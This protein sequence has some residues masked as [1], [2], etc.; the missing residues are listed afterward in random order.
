M[1][2][3]IIALAIASLLPLSGI[4]QPMM[5]HSS[6]HNPCI[7]DGTKCNPM[8]TQGMH[9]GSWHNKNYRGYENHRQAMFRS[10]NLS[11]EQQAVFDKEMQANRDKHQ[12]IRNQYTHPMTDEQRQSMRAEHMQLSTAA[13]QRMR[14]VLNAEQKTEFDKIVSQRRIDNV[15]HMQNRQNYR[16]S[17]Q[18]Q[19][20]RGSYRMNSNHPHF[21]NLNLTPEQQAAF[22][23]EMQSSFEKHQAVRDRH[24]PRLSPEQRQTMFNESQKIRTE[25]QEKLR[26]ILTPEQQVE[27]DKL[28]N[29]MNRRTNQPSVK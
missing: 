10:L 18:G 8:H 2:T 4:A 23:K 14:A 17:H 11:P 5:G 27:F 9:R 29:Q 20:N 22:D 16:G 7:N 26:A 15:Q 3:S 21:Y 24:M 12:Q 13:H 28:Q 25:T 1:R 6:N 19:G